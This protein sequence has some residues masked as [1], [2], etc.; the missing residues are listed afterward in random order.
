MADHGRHPAVL[1][2]GLLLQVQLQL[3]VDLQLRCQLIQVVA[4]RVLLIVDQQ[5]AGQVDLRRQGRVVGVLGKIR[6]IQWPGA[7]AV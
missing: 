2:L 6:S 5:D 1:A 7:P 3:W 4:F